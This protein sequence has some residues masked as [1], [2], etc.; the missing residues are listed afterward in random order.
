MSIND[1]PKRCSQD[2]SID[3]SSLRIIIKAI[4]AATLNFTSISA[5]VSL[6][7]N[8]NNLQLISNR[9]NVIKS[10]K[11]KTGFSNIYMRNK[12]YYVRIQIQNKMKVI[13]GFKN[14]ES[15]VIKRNELLNIFD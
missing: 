4:P 1:H 15:A 13:Y 14:I 5:V 3:L 6:N 10:K 2:S 7:N 9:D 8:L 11:S 12:T